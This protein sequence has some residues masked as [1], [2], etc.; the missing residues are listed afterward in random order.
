M[1]QLTDEDRAIHEWQMWVRDFGEEG[2]VRLK[3]ASALVSRTGGIG[4][5]IA[6][7]LAMAGVGKLVLAHG[8]YLKR[9]DLNRQVT[10]TYGHLGKQRVESSVRR[11]KYIKPDIEIVGVP[12]NMTEDNAGELVAMADIAFDASPLYSER[13]AMNRACVEQGKPMVHA[14]MYSFEGQVTTIIPGE[15]PCLA[16]IYPESPPEWKREFPVIGAVSATAGMLAT[17]EGIKHIIG[18]GASLAGK[19]LYFDSRNM[20]FM[21]VP[22]ARRADCPIC[23]DL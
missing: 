23:G 22:I 14:A 6:Q 19:M 8:G 11:L 13:F 5:P 16:C 12:E 21:K 20:E 18:I 17:I 10:M 1:K 3:N 7:E 4:G 2:Q 9:S 15:T